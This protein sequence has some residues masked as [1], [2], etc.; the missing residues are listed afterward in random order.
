MLQAFEIDMYY[1]K[2]VN[3]FTSLR[4]VRKTVRKDS[5]IDV[6]NTSVRNYIDYIETSHNIRMVADPSCKYGENT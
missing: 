2:I 3:S 6:N 4:K 1:D 5:S